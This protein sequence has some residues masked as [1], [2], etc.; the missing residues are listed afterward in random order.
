MKKKVFLSIILLLLVGIALLFFFSNQALDWLWYRNLGQTSVFWIPLLTKIFFYLTLGIFFFVFLFFNLRH[1]RKAFSELSTGDGFNSSKHSLL[2][3]LS[4]LG[5]TFFLLP[6]LSLDWS[7]VQ[8]FLHKTSYGEFDPIFNKDLGF[9]LFS[10]P[11]Y[12]KLALSFLGLIILSLLSTTLF[13]LLAQA[14]WAKDNKGQFWP[15][16]R[17]HLTLLGTLFFLVKAWDH[18]LSKYGLLYQEHSLLTGVNFTAKHIKIL[19]CNLL[20]VMAIV[21]GILFIWSLFNKRPYRLLLTGIGLWLVT[22]ILFGAVLPPVVDSLLV[23]PNQFIVEEKFLNYHIQF[24][25][26]G[27]GLNQI[28]EEAYDIDENADLKLVEDNHPS[29]ENLRIWDWRP[30]LPA[31]NQLQSIRSY[32]TFKDL[33]IDRYSTATGEKQVMIAA[34]ELDPEQIGRYNWLNSHLTY[35]HGYGLAVNEI[36]KANK[37]GQPLFLIKDLPPVVNP[38]FPELKLTRPEIYFGEGKKDYIIV[39]TKEKEFDYPL[40][41]GKSITTT[42]QGRDG[43]SLRRPLIRLLF[44]A[45]LRESNLILSGYIQEKSRILLHRNIKERVTKLAPFL[46]LDSDPYLVV[47]D[48]RLFWMIDAYTSSQYFPYSRKHQNGFNYIRNSVKVVVDAYH[49]T[50]D[51]YIIDEKDPLIKTWEKVFPGLFKPFSIMP[52]TLKKHIRYPEFL[53][54]MQQDILLNYHMTDPKAFY[55][56]EDYWHLPTQIYDS[57]EEVVKPS[58]VTLLLPGEEEEEFLL[59]QTFTPYGKQNMIAW[60]VARC[61]QPNYGQLIL[62]HLPKGTNTY[63]PMQVEARIGQNPQISEMISLWNQN[64]SR[65]IRGNLMVI[66]LENTILYAEPF[67]IVSEQGEIPELKKIVM[68]YKDQVVIGDSVKEAFAQLKMD[69]SPPLPAVEPPSPVTD[70]AELQESKSIDPEVLEALM[71]IDNKLHEAQDLI[72]Q[73]K[74]S[75][76]E[77]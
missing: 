66:P 16:A 10:Y 44:A 35:T 58:Y 50:V 56:K 19:G 76:E 53:F 69:I 20:T 36:S 28:K 17:I 34:R 67:Y 31:Y 57:S 61:G 70:K 41:T 7:I 15:R 33:D 9:Y 26:L 46:S 37:G 75:L 22:S 27:F 13:Y 68:V 45:K 18:N 60:L 43:I 30:L 77:N 74:D 64:Q 51:F 5:L 3:V 65:L 48:G 6:G 8:Q 4:A 52:E 62:Y 14:Y 21:A 24:T 63:G 25:R 55:E 40:G 54:S 73:L 38:D 11:L 47:A 49:G 2:S 71:E 42:Y 29:L 32:Y 23:K 12:Q 1:T 72:E 59:M 39:R